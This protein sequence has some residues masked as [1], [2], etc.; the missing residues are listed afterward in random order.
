MALSNKLCPPE[1]RKKMSVSDRITAILTDAL[2]PERLEV[3]NESHR[4]AGHAGDD[5]SGETHYQVVIVSDKFTGCSRVECHRM[6]YDLL[7]SELKG[8]IHALSIKASVP[9]K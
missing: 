3:I 6:V 2:Q 4:H 5:G 8:S 9:S 7:E 1:K